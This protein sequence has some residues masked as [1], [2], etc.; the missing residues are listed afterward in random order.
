MLI[1]GVLVA[2]LCLA[3]LKLPPA[4]ALTAAAATLG[5]A[6]YVFQHSRR[7][8]AEVFRYG[9]ALKHAAR[10]IAECVPTRFVVMGHTHEPVMEKI[11]AMTTYVNLGAWAVDE[12]AEE[13]AHKQAPRTHLVIRHDAQGEPQAGLFRWDADTG[14]HRIDAVPPASALIA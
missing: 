10:R 8:R 5:S 4:F 2:L 6:G 7:A 12:L 9:E 11:S 14:V 3:F 1:A 13:T